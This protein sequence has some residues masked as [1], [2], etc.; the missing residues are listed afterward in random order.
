MTAL[1]GAMLLTEGGEEFVFDAT[2]SIEPGAEVD[3][4]EYEVEEGAD[5]ADHLRVKSRTLTL[6]GILTDTPGFEAPA[7]GRASQLLNRLHELQ[8]AR[9]L[10]TVVSNFDVYEG[11]AVTGIKATRSATVGRAWEVTVELRELRKATTATAEIPAAL[12]KPKVKAKAPGEV[13]QGNQT[14]KPMSDE[15]FFAAD[16]SALW[17]IKAGAKKLLGL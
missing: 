5:V 17:D 14:G 3:V 4:S 15:E 9:E 13:D 16:S 2:T 12:L 10:V 8:R 7:E 11:F 1:W 6:T